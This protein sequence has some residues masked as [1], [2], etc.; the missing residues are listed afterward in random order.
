M[1]R[2]VSA[3]TSV[4]YIGDSATTNPPTINA[5]TDLS[6]NIS[7]GQELRVYFG[8]TQPGGTAIENTPSQTGINQS[9]ILVFGMMCNGGGCPGS[10]ITYGQTIP[11]LGMLVE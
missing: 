5:Y 2:I 3:S 1:T 11:F 7:P 10:G 4:F 8:A 6:Q 9:P